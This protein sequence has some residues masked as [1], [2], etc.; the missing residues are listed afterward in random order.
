[1]VP[2]MRLIAYRAPGAA[3]VHPAD[4]QLGLPPGRHPRELAKMTAA[5][6][7]AGLIGAPDA[8]SARVT[9]HARR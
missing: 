7:A 6:A 9:R 1:M 4:G 8:G 3:A 2:V 5:A